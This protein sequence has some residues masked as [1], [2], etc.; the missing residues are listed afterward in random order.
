M[1]CEGDEEKRD[2]RGGSR[3]RVVVKDVRWATD[4]RL[5]REEAIERQSLFRAA[6]RTDD[7]AS[8]RTQ[9]KKQ[10][11]VAPNVAPLLNF[12]Q[13]CPLLA[14]YLQEVPLDV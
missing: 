1:R 11:G 4:T 12:S 14:N 13:S 3:Q 2:G 8:A 5:L 7:A 10:I 6:S 9:M